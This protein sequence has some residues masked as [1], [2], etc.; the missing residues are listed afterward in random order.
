MRILLRYLL[1]SILYSI[2]Y[3]CY[4]QQK[5][6]SINK[7]DTIIK[8]TLVEGKNKIILGE[9]KLKES[10]RILNK[11]FQIKKDSSKNKTVT[12]F[13]VRGSF[14]KKSFLKF[15]GGL[16]NYNYNYRSFIDTP[17]AG[18]NVSQHYLFGNLNFQLANILPIRVNYLVR[19]SNSNYLKN[20]KDV[21]LIFD[22]VSYRNNLNEKIHKRLLTSIPMLTDSLTALDFQLKMKEYGSM[23]DWLQNPF[24]IQKL[25]ES[26]EILQ[27]PEIARNYNLPDSISKARADSMISSARR[28]MEYY[29][30][31]KNQYD[32]LKEQI[33]SL[34]QSN[35]KTLAKIQKYKELI[36]KPLNNVQDYNNL[37][38]QLK[39]YNINSEYLNKYKWMLGIKQIG[40]GKNTINYSELTAKNINSTGINIE[41]NSWYYLALSAGTVDYRFRDF[42]I[43]PSNKSPQYL[44]M[45]RFGIGN[46]Q[47]NNVIFSIF[48]GQKQIYAQNNFSSTSSNLNINGLSLEAKVFLNSNSYVK[49]E[50]AQSQIPAYVYNRDAPK[51]FIN[52]SDKTNKGLSLKL[53]YYLPRLQTTID[54]MYKYTGA[55]YQSFS[56]FQTNSS[57]EAWHIKLGQYFFKRNLK[58]IA[59]IKSNEF[60]NPFII[61]NYRTS[62]IFK[63][64]SATYSRRKYP[65]ISFAF[66]PITQLTFL[67]NEYSESKFYSLSSTLNYSYRINEVPA[68]T[69]VVYSKFYNTQA[70]SSYF[71]Y[72]S[73]N[74]LINQTFI[75]KMFTEG[76]GISF[77]DNNKYQLLVIDGSLSLNFK[78]YNSFGL[79]AKINNL[80]KVG[81]YWNIQTN[82]KKLGIFRF[83]YDQGYLPGNNYKLIRNDNL[84]LSFTKTI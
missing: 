2:T 10:Y 52:L 44:Y 38:Q 30:N 34:K 26:Q 77:S 27:I 9:E 36:N 15:N 8:R 28:F 62:T 60:T 74:L 58:I 39:D 72:N 64:F 21:Q 79:G 37:K 43:K 6:S 5:D 51:K 75:N 70:D 41:Y 13:E 49:G 53:Y 81:T 82:I 45:G 7:S 24:Q 80:S 20:I 76:F 3:N 32:S 83:R 71:F 59:S 42:V 65:T 16:V 46:I 29:S 56:S 35:E 84:N 33:D 31:K 55:N 61:Q 50:I 11:S 48:K 23:E 78:K 66:S 1:V 73:N 25:I 12:A 19:Y 69:T 68:M 47:K 67:N 4:S 18:T 57:L 54:G 14:E 17:F 40:I 22:G 63:S